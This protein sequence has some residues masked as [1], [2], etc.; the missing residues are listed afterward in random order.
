MGATRPCTG[1]PP[2]RLRGREAEKPRRESSR[3]G[4][5]LPLPQP[6]RAGRQAGRQ[7]PPCPAAASSPSASPPPDSC[8][9]PT[10]SSP[11]AAFPGKPRWPPVP[12][13]GPGQAQTASAPASGSGREGRR[14]MRSVVRPCLPLQSGRLCDPRRALRG[15]EGWRRWWRR[16]AE[17]AGGDSTS[18]SQAAKPLCSFGRSSYVRLRK[19]R[20]C[21]CQCLPQT[22]PSP[23]GKDLIE[24]VF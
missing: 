21:N 9:H 12:T 8:P 15:E 18:L 5:R 23:P 10:T 14:G 2:I 13:P 24:R 6:G 3:F 19:G 1:G 11:L 4:Q 20:T 16:R 22:A 17:E 7:S